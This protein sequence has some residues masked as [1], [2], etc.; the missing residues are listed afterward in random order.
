MIEMIIW[1][2]ENIYG[3]RRYKFL[4]L[5][6]KEEFLCKLHIECFFLRRRKNSVEF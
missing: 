6:E 1:R 3:E 5:L 4:H 2:M